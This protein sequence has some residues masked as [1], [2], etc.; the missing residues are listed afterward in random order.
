MLDPIISLAFTLSSNK[1]C[2]ALMLGSGISRSAHI[3]TGWE[4]TLDLIEKIAKLIGEDT[5]NDPIKWFKKKYNTSADYSSL[6]NALTHVP[7]E[8]SSLLAGYFEPNESERKKRWKMPTKAHNAIAN[9]I[10][11]EYIKVVITTNFDRLLEMA[12]DKKGIQPKVISSADQIEG[13]IPLMHMKRPLI[14]KV[15]GDYLDTR[16][17]NTED[18]L[19]SYDP[20][21][22]KLVS[23]ILED[24]GV[25]VC[26]WSGT[27]D[28]ELVN[29]FKTTENKIFNCYWIDKYP[30]NKNVK[31][32]IKNKDAT[33]IKADADE[34]FVE[35]AKRVLN[36]DDDDSF[37]FHEEQE[38]SKKRIR[39]KTKKIAKIEFIP[40]ESAEELR[41][42]QLKRISAGQ[43]SFILPGY[44]RLIIHLIPNSTISKKSRFN[45]DRVADNLKVIAPIG[46]DPENEKN[47]RISHK[48]GYTVILPNG[49]I[50][51][52][53]T[54][55]LTKKKRLPID[56]IESVAMQSLNHYLARIRALRLKP[57]ISLLIS[58]LGVEDYEIVPKSKTDWNTGFKIKENEVHCPE[59]VFNRFPKRITLEQL[60]P[61]FVHIWKSA[62]FKFGG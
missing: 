33:F 32:F 61:A 2:Y 25:I 41:I 56:E 48:N 7:S 58:L 15:N 54:T 20:R 36:L 34:L 49:S 29:L 14:L 37:K 9:L 55:M 45:L 18:E 35:V 4:I 51:A 43:E 60:R 50:E 28:K 31:T 3:P 27:Y 19:S 62:G 23:R 47:S 21:V 26:G 52:V 39:R 10:A 1:G 17:K 59:I 11:G 22:S 46:I 44:S 12:L 6:L 5:G 30:P 40:A 42:N 13:S 8:R 24:F 53:D 16:I 57:P 38:P